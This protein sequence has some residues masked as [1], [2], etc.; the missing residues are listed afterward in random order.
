MKYNLIPSFI[1]D[2][3]RESWILSVDDFDNLFIFYDKG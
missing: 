3:E 2:D 1:I